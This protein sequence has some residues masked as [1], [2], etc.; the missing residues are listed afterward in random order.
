MFDHGLLVSRA[1]AISVLLLVLAGYRPRFICIPHWYVAFSMATAM[2]DSDGADR[3]LQVAAM[4]LIP[5]C[6]GDD[7]AWQ[8]T[9]PRDPMP[10]VWRGAAFTGMIALRV[11]L[12]VIYLTAATTKLMDPLWRQGSVMLAI[13][14]H[15]YAGFPRALLELLEP[16]L[17]SY[18]PVATA[19][20]LVI[21]VQLAMAV[22]IWGGR[23]SRWCAF[24]LG[25]GLHAG[26]I[27]FM[28]LAAFG[29]AVIGVLVIVCVPTERRHEDEHEEDRRSRRGRTVRP[30]TG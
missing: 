29:I 28:Q 16:V 9:R 1:L 22:L 24:V 21:A 14:H 5:V 18:W 15:P 19:G 10:D 2:P 8:W 7:R 4:L 27:V 17:R 20:W 6:L 30:R 12:C 23:R 25:V 11:Q 3:I 26:I 13:A